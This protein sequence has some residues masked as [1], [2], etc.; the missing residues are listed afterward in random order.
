MYINF[1]VLDKAQ[2]T[3]PSFVLL[4][5]VKQNDCDKLWMD[6][7]HVEK[8]MSLLLRNG[9]VDHRKSDNWY[10]ITKKGN[11]FLRDVGTA[12]VTDEVKA[13]FLKLVQLYKDYGRNVGSANKALKVFAQ[14]VEETKNL[15]TFDLIVETVEEYLINSEPQYTARLDLFIWKPANAYARKFT[16]EDS[17]LYTKCRQ[18]A[19]SIS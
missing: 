3:Y 5:A 19:N 14:F 15:F 16:I 1:D 10:K 12:G 7:D 9:L 11:A 18:N 17:R 4:I 13:T 6:S 8:Y 2:M